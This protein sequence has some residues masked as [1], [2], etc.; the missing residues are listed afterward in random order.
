MIVIYKVTRWKLGKF[1]NAIFD[2]R[3]SSYNR[4][5]Y[6]HPIFRRHAST[7]KYN[8]LYYIQQVEFHYQLILELQKSFK[9]P[10]KILMLLTILTPEIIYLPYNHK[11]HHCWEQIKMDI[12]RENYWFLPTVEIPSL[13]IRLWGALLY[14]KSIQVIKE[15]FLVLTQG[16]FIPHLFCLHKYFF[17]Q[18]LFLL[19]EI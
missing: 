13:K 16:V 19:I 2:P 7:L 1:A 3:D 5:T 8:I 6:K 12:Q 10:N 17:H 14:E 9:S 18:L 11:N 4:K 15:S